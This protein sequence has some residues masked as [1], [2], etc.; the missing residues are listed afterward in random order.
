MKNIFLPLVAAR[1]VSSDRK[2]IFHTTEKIVTIEA[3]IKLIQEL[4]ALCDGTR[5]RDQIVQSLA[6]KWD[7]QTVKQ[8][9]GALRRQTVLV[10]AH[11]VGEKTWK[12]VQNPSCFPNHVSAADSAKLAHR[13][14][15]RILDD[16]CETLYQVKFG[17]FA[18][19]LAKRQSVRLFSGAAV[20]FQSIINILW[21]AYGG[22]K[23]QDGRGSYKTVPSAGALYP[24]LIHVALFQPTDDLLPGLYRVYLGR[25][26]SVGCHFV[27]KDTEKLS[28]AFLNPLTLEKAHGVIVISGSF[29]VTGEKYG[30]RSLLYVPLEAGHAAQNIHLAAVEEGVATVEIGGFADVLLSQA[31]DLPKHHQP[32]ITVVFGQKASD[33]QTADA[34]QQIELQW[35]I[36]TNGRYNPPFAIASARVSEKRSWSHG[37]D[38]SPALAAIKALAEA[39]EWAACG[40]IP[41]NLIQAKFVDLE[42]A[43]DPRKIISYH[44]AQYRLK[45]FPFKAFNETTE[46]EW[47]EGR[48]E[49]VGSIVNV[50]ADLVYFPYFPKSAYYTYANS[51]GVAAHPNREKALETST[52]ELIERDSFMIAYLTRIEFPTVLEQTLPADIRKRLTGLRK[53]G[54]RVWVKDHSVDLAPVACVIAQ[55]QEVTYTACASCSSFDIGYALNHALM[56]VEAMVLARLENGPTKPIKPHEVIWPLDHG[57]L[58][59][60]Q[61]YFRKADFLIRSRIK[62]AFRD[63]GKAMARSWPELLNQFQTKGW[64]LFTIPL[65]LSEEYGGNDGLH[66][67]RSFVPGLVPMT[68]GYHQE[69]GGMDRIYATARKIGLHDIS[70]GGLTKFPH[71]FA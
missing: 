49:I 62:I 28:R 5:S 61:R 19:L 65:Y 9:L 25:A 51:S 71:P 45:R 58:Y 37:R 38:A 34:N 29:R 8:M 4:V 27:S 31:I 1:L 36:P 24:L 60:Q 30:N 42:G 26:G 23:S 14:A 57:G 13:A 56:E 53:A 59:G 47:T 68:F 10:D 54:F 40:C 52:L 41:H 7:G 6:R 17:A 32:L 39:K 12:M 63:M 15:Q 44:P 2:V 67:I 35:S 16:E 33:G 3:P 55:S 22:L 20:S 21:S 50:L 70:Y 66:I 64:R 46:Y 43:I 18:S 11:Q 69:P 48:D